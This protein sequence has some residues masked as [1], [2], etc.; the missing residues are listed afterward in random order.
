MLWH[1]QQ[2]AKASGVAN[3]IVGRTSNTVKERLHILRV[4]LEEELVRI[5]RD[6]V[7]LCYVGYELLL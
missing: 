2:A 4:R 1:L 7:P 3:V 6:F 5:E